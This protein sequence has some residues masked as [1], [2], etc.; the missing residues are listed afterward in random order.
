M[1]IPFETI[2]SALL[3]RSEHYLRQWF[4]LGKVQGTEFL[5]GNIFG[6]SGESL[7]INMVKGVG[8]DFASGDSFGDLIDVYAAHNNLSI[9]QA[10]TELMQ[11]LGIRDDAPIRTRVPVKKA[12]RNIGDWLSAWTEAAVETPPNDAPTDPSAFPNAKHGYPDHVYHYCDTNGKLRWVICRWDETPTRRKNFTPYTWSNGSWMPK[13]P[14]TPRSLY[15][16]ETLT[17]KGTVIIVEGEKAA[18]AAR[19]LFPGCPVVSAPN[20]ASSVKNAD[21]NDIA[22]R[23]IVVWPDADEAGKKWLDELMPILKLITESVRVVDVSEHGDGW[24]AADWQGTPAQAW[25]WIKGRL[26]EWTD[27]KIKADSKAGKTVTLVNRLELWE[28]LGLERK[29]NGKP[30]ASVDN[31]ERILGQVW[32]NSLHYDSFLNQ[33]RIEKNG[34]IE[35]INDAHV[36]EILVAIQRSYGVQEAG[37]KSVRQAII[38]HC[39]KNKRNCLQEWLNSL[40]WDG[41]PRIEQLFITGFGAADNNYTRSVGRCFLIGMI[42]RALNP[43][44]QVDTMPILEGA[45]GIGKTRGIETLAGKDFYA[46]IDATMGSREFIEQ[47]QGRWVVEI[48]ELSAMRAGDVER[49]KTTLTKTVDVYRE[50]YSTFAT[51]HP[52]QCVFIGSTNA[53]AYLLDDSGN[54]RFLP[55]A[56]TEVDRSWIKENRQQL[57]AEAV[58]AYKQGQLWYD[59]PLDLAKTEQSKREFEDSL[60]EKIRTYGILKDTISIAEM[61]Y[62]WQIP[63]DRQTMQ[64]QKRI[65]SCLKRL[66]YY[67]IKSGG[68]IMWRLDALTLPPAAGTVTPIRKAKVLD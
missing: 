50:P 21:W 33:N 1:S 56:C 40:T 59:L 2:R 49:V 66:G 35:K 63:P 38:L 55:I 20:G 67:R 68:L 3:N 32:G 42:A 23:K 65:A 29:S 62:D 15:G 36:L 19:R 10:A 30:Y 11:Q 34:K 26:R 12:D 24:D 64:F 22:G 58:A 37:E 9:K 5:I 60:I 44:C 16:L 6:D 39:S 53:D 4:P 52:R 8:K 41:T 54:R 51:D 27:P 31:F 46:D 48:S 61:L 14:P 28:S 45:Q 18:D 43:G 7:K 47:V 25:E 57:I 17:R 13:A